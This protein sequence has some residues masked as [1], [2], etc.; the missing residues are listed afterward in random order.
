MAPAHA[1]DSAV[2]PCPSSL[3]AHS[4]PQSSPSCSLRPSPTV[5][6]SPCPGTALPPRAPSCCV[7][8]WTRVP[9]WD[10]Q[11]CSTDCEVLTPR[12]LSQIHRFTLQQPQ[13]L[14]LPPNWLP[15]CG[16]LTAVSALPTPARRSGLLT[17]P[18]P[19]SFL[20]PTKFC[21]NL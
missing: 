13:T 3:Q 20:L 8:Q 2:A 14:P 21:V 15:R 7:L 11:G 10:T 12:R 6:S 5:D 1:C 18:F 4:L 9:V 16:D 19:P 17:L